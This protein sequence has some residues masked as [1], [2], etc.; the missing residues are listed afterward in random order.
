MQN[1]S[2]AYVLTI[3]NSARK[4]L[5]ERVLLFLLPRLSPGSFNGCPPLKK[6]SFDFVQFQFFLNLSISRIDLESV[7]DFFLKTRF[8]AG[9]K[10]FS[11]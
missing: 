4:C 7:A 9:S 5:F 1:P 3:N 6:K 2:S 8:I 11:E 10:V